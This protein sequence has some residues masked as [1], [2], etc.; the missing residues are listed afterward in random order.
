MEVDP[1]APA[2]PARRCERS[3]LLAVV[4]LWALAAT[5]IGL[6]A[7]GVVMPRRYQ[8][9]FLFWGLGQSVA[10][11][12]GLV[13]RGAPIPIVAPLY[14]YVIAPVFRLADSVS[15]QYEL[16]RALNSALIASVVFPV[17]GFARQLVGVRAALLAA[18]LCVA[19]P[20]VNYAGIIGTESLAYPLAALA[21][22]AMVRALSRPGIASGALAIGCIA[23]AMATRVQ[24][25]ALGAVLALA[26][27]VGVALQSRELR[28]AYLRQRRALI[29][30]LAAG[31]SLVLGYIAVRG[32]AAAGIYGSALLRRGF[33]SGD[34]AYWLRAF[35]SDLFVLSGIAPTIATFALLG[36]IRRQQN[37]WV[38][39]L[40][41]VA[42]AASIVFVLQLSWFS[43][44][45]TENWRERGIFYQR[46]MFYLG[47]LF[48][49][50]FVAAFGR[51]QRRAVVVSGVVAGALLL[52]MPGGIVSPPL[53]IDAFGHAYIAF[54]ISDHESAAGWIA[55]SLAFFA[56]LCG[57]ALL[58][59][60]AG[61]EDPAE[62]SSAVRI[63]RLLAVV[64]PLAFLLLAQAKAWSLQRLYAQDTLAAFAQPPGWAA[65]R[66]DVQSAILVGRSADKATV[67]Q[68][69][70]WNPGVNRIYTSERAPVGS[71]P[72]F[73][74]Q[75]ILELDRRGVVQAGAVPGCERP[76]RGWVVVG[77]TL[78]LS[79]R[80]ASTLA[81]PA[82][83]ARGQSLQVTPARPQVLALVGGRETATGNVAGE[84]TIRSFALRS[85][86]L[87]IRVRGS[88]RVWRTLVRKVPA[89]DTTT[90]LVLSRP[91][92]RAAKVTSIELRERGGQAQSLL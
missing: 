44:T 6:A 2:G 38:V 37:P 76:P 71:P 65:A 45:N 22:L 58:A 14:V 91:G 29:V 49:V 31:A 52:L 85:A 47:P 92:G 36:G 59:F 72:Y 23:L 35:T 1:V 11:G 43:I 68:T 81:R 79:M 40:V 70:F 60:A 83:N 64:L 4:A 87:R 33:P 57:L 77:P 82:E 89:L 63:G 39:S 90:S 78:S 26:L 21:L 16:I 19:V 69:E 3:G 9:E 80:G 34:V 51:V 10:G 73:A 88:D 30:L 18:G 42:L 13:W 5:I 48:F 67:F 61:R 27:L 84:L 8:D 86:E 50:G 17:Y 62:E 74:P 7:A 24:F 28:R 32:V 46:Y 53:S 12:H 55:P 66:S 56:L 20:A 15:G 41:A 25:A 75:C 54:L